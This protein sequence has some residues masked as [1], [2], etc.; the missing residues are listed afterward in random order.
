MN[1]LKNYYNTNLKSLILS[2]HNLLN[3]F[4]FPK[5]KKV[6]FKVK[7]KLKENNKIWVVL[8]WTGFLLTGQ[9]PTLKKRKEHASYKDTSY[10]CIF[11]IS[12][13]KKAIFSFL[14]KYIYFILPKMEQL[15]YFNSK[16]NRN[17][18][19][20][21]VGGFMNHFESIEIFNFLGDSEISLINAIEFEVNI[22]FTTTSKLFNI[23]LLRGLQIPVKNY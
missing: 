16:S 11:K 1:F 13:T 6:D 18:L 17:Q 22:Y 8:F 14:T 4:T 15:A 19:I 21:R 3:T 20:C 23:N 9:K 12:L 7:S 10:I 2:K 5:I